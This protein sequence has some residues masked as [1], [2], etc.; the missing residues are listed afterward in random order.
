M[1]YEKNINTKTREL[2]RTVI[3]REYDFNKLCNLYGIGAG[4]IYTSAIF[5]P[6]LRLHLEQDYIL[7][8]LSNKPRLNSYGQSRKAPAGSPYY[9]LREERD[10]M[11]NSRYLNYILDEDDQGRIWC[12]SRSNTPK[13][14]LGIGIFKY[15]Y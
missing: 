2:T 9:M 14:I 10:R 7:R 4:G 5:E 8:V 11:Y 6:Y 1:P 15:V 12:Q 3:I 13:T